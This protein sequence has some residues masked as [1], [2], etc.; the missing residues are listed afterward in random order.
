MIILSISSRGENVVDPF[1]VRDD[2]STIDAEPCLRKNSI[3]DGTP[4]GHRIRLF[5][6]TS[7]VT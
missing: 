3:I 6:V 1:S 4:T 7:A 2:S 5:I